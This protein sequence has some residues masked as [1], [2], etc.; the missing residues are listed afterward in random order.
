[1]WQLR[2]K[3]NHQLLINARYLLNMLELSFFGYT[4]HEVGVSLINIRSAR[5]IHAVK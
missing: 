3:H 5:S 1:M 4:P 2:Y